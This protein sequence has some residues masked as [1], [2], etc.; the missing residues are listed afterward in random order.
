MVNYS[1]DKHMK[2]KRNGIEKRLGNVY[3]LISCVDVREIDVLRV[4]RKYVY[5]EVYRCKCV[6]EIYLYT[7]IMLESRAERTATLGNR[8]IFQEAGEHLRSIYK[9]PANF[10]RYFLLSVSR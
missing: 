4:Y 1:I 6:V 8:V 3:S 5:V 9:P 7:C 10:R 2:Y